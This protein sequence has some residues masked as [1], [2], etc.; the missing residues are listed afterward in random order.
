ENALFNTARLL[1]SL[2]RYD[3]AAG[4]YLRYVDLYPKGED[5]PKQQFHAALI[6]EKQKDYNK[7]IGALKEFLTRYNKD[8]KQNDF[9][10]DA[11]KKIAD[12]YKAQGKEADAKKAYAD[13][14]DEFD[15]RK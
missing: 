13:A 15:K 8:S 1:E 14:A 3:Q 5:A 4:A 10:I 12:A 9:L 7:E 11:R 6:Y 2:E